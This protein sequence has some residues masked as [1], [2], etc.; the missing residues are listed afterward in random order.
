MKTKLRKQ[1]LIE[2][3]NHHP[4]QKRRKDLAIVKK[5]TAIK[6][7]NMAAIVLFYLPIHGE[8]DLKGLFEK[9][10][11]NKNF[12]L[13]R[14]NSK[15]ASLTLYQIKNIK[16]LEI[17][18]YKMREPK[19][20]LPKIKPAQIELALIPGIA[21]S[22]DGHRIGYGKGFYDRLLKKTRCPKIG[23]AYDFQ[24]VNN[25]RGEL[26]DTP[27]DCIITE[28]RIIKCQ[29]VKTKSLRSKQNNT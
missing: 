22:K 8:V 21:F 15:Q 11:L 19:R 9:L 25:I 7:F 16:D 4:L 10:K 1:K 17:G 12:V 24:I 18:S 28:K 20:K 3:L 29:Q 5:L 26:H 2:R 13:P 23:V 14:I 27:M 6:E